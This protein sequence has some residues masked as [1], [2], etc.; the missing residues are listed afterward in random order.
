MGHKIALQ[1]EFENLAELE[2]WWAKLFA[3]PQEAKPPVDLNE[4]TIQWD[5]REVWDILD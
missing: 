4:V 1:L 2:K 3:G 5:S